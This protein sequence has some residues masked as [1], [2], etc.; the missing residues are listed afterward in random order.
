MPRHNV[1]DRL[2]KRDLYLVSEEGRKPDG[3]LINGRN[4]RATASEIVVA[5]LTTRPDRLWI[6]GNDTVPGFLAL[7]TVFNA[8]ERDGTRGGD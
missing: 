1:L 5:I 4:R 6:L 7:D 2:C 3:L 8:Q